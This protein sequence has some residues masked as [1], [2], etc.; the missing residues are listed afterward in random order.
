MLVLEPDPERRRA[1]AC[2]V[3]G[4]GVDVFELG[5]LAALC[6]YLERSRRRPDLL[7]IGVPLANE[8]EACRMMTSNPGLPILFV[9]PSA[10]GRAPSGAPAHPIVVVDGAR[11][12]EALARRVLA[13]IR[14]AAAT[15][16]ARASA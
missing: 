8:A 9:A 6:W 10:G 1:L 5:E 16:Q 14:A 13:T 2:F 15:R 3:R 4:A 7:V 12:G 11:E